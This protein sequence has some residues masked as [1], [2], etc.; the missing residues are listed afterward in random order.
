MTVKEILKLRP[1]FRIGG[2]MRMVDWFQITEGG[3]VYHIRSGLRFAGDQYRSPYFYEDTVIGKG[4]KKK[5]LHRF[6]EWY[7][8]VKELQ[9]EKQSERT[10]LPCIP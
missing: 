2:G 9:N 4:A 1:E 10:N 8:K 7:Q 5:A 6:N 3:S